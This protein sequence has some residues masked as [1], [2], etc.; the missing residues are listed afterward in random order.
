MTAQYSELRVELFDCCECGRPQDGSLAVV[1]MMGAT[2]LARAR[3]CPGIVPRKSTTM[4]TKAKK[5]GSP[6]SSLLTQELPDF[7]TALKR[8]EES[9]KSSGI[10]D[11]PAASRHATSCPHLLEF[12]PHALDLDFAQTEKGVW[13]LRNPVHAL[14]LESQLDALEL[15]G[16][17]SPPIL[18][19]EEQ[20][21]FLALLTRGFSDTWHPYTHRTGVVSMKRKKKLENDEQR[22]QK[23][24][25]QQPRRRKNSLLW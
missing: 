20:E 19:E 23:Q 18:Y 24:D 6:S 4:T 14:H 7:D 22:R 12:L 21:R 25:W 5:T 11:Y 10:A 3:G 8:A 1:T 16:T 2:S 9:L 15:K 17:K 13:L